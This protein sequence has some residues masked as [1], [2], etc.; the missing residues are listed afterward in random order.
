MLCEKCGGEM[1][2]NTVN[3]KNPKG[4]DYKCKDVNCGHA[5]WL[6]SKGKPPV[7]PLPQKPP[8]N[9]VSADMM[10]LAY[11]KDLMV[12]V[13]NRWGETQDSKTLIEIFATLWAEVE[14]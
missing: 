3:K 7:K 9:G 13:V 1:W 14:K 11:R 12:A 2:D 10:R 8:V 4:P 5:V 6:L